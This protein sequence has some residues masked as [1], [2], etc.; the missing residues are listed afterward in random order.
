MA[1]QHRVDAVPARP[2]RHRQQ[3]ELVAQ[4]DA[5]RGVPL[6]H[7]DHPPRLDDQPVAAADPGRA[8][9]HDVAELGR[10]HGVDRAGDD[11]QSLAPG[12]DVPAAERGERGLHPAGRGADEVGEL[13]DAHVATVPTA[14]ERT[15]TRHRPCDVCSPAPHR[16]PTASTGDSAA[17]PRA[18][19]RGGA[20]RGGG[21]SVV[22]VPG[23][24]G[25]PLRRTDRR[26]RAPA[27]R[28]RGAALRAALHLPTVRRS[29]DGAARGAALWLAAAAWT[30]TSVAALAVTL[31]TFGLSAP[32]WSRS[33]SG[34]WRWTRCGRR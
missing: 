23:P 5:V 7:V 20:G 30:A 6:Q 10:G 8:Q 15:A 22:D 33:S 12:G 17:A 28:R 32:G 19:G 14:S 27:V 16:A 1:E 21:H 13:G 9:L 29:G 4:L 31:R 25:L 34:C 26:R 18:P 2:A 24:D 11:E 3:R